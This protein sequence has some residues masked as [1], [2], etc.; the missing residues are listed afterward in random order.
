[1]P[2][3]PPTNKDKPELQFVTVSA[4]IYFSRMCHANEGCLVIKGESAIGRQVI[5]NVD[6]ELKGKLYAEFTASN[7]SFA[8]EIRTAENKPKL[9]YRQTGARRVGSVALRIEGRKD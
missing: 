4:R 1:M 2:T 8:R 5:T 6:Q 3:P 7:C 9:A